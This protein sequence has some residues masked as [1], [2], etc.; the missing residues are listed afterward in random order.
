M[1]KPCEECYNMIDSSVDHVWAHNPCR[2][3]PHNEANKLDE[4]LSAVD[5]GVLCTLTEAWKSVVRLEIDLEDARQT[6]ALNEEL[7]ER[8]HIMLESTKKR[9]ERLEELLVLVSEA[10]NTKWESGDELNS[11]NHRIT[12]WFKSGG[13]EDSRKATREAQKIVDELNESRRLTFEDLHKPFMAPEKKL[14][15]IEMTH[16]EIL[17]IIKTPGDPSPPLFPDTFAGK[18][19]ETFFKEGK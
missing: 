10:V 1:V 18:V 5:C 4:N 2:A 11:L 14:P 7:F 6:A 16:E 12:E 8:E 15:A 17:G 13:E 19:N 9:V 3:C